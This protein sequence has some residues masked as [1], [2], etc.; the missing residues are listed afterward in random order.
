M[1]TTSANSNV[2][3]RTSSLITSI[4]EEFP[5]FRM[6]P[7]ESSLLCSVID[8]CLRF[9]TL[10]RQSRFMTEYFTVLGETLYLAPTWERMDDRE[11]YVLL[12]HERVHLRQRRR[13]GNLRMAFLY[14][15]PFFP[16]GLAWGRAKIEWEAYEETLRATAE[17]YGFESLL[18]SGLKERLVARFTG[19]DYGFM[20]P[21]PNQVA[22]WYERALARIRT[23]G[24]GNPILDLTTEGH[25]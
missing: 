12:S 25:R 15:V 8:R 17:V 19:P 23:Q 22:R 6:R 20:W 5:R 16:M 10:G 18:R 1:A 7:K 2:L 13:Y 14:I 24:I 4:Q 3:S 11:K 21:F 9:V